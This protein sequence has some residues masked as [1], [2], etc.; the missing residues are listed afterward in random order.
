MI[1]IGITG[2]FGA[3]KG[4]LSKYLEKRYGFSHYLVRDIL[5]EEINKKNLPLNRESMV[6]VADD[7]RKNKS[8]GYLMEEICRKAIQNGDRKIIIDSI[9][10]PGEIETLR[11]KENFYLIYIDAS[12][13]VRYERIM[14]RKS[15]TDK[16]SFSEFKKAELKEMKSDDPAKINLSKCFKRADFH[17]INDGSLENL[18]KKVDEVMKN[19]K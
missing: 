10:N 11:K 17:I 2:T 3:G 4:T 18:F 8:N 15:E 9:R 19:L 13:E 14:N 6:I 1:I 5:I 7:F 16:I 12:P